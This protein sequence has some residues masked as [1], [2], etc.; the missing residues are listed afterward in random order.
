MPSVVI[1]AG[2]YKTA[3]STIQAIAQ[4]N[5]GRFLEAFGLLYPKTGARANQGIPDPDSVA[6][7]L[8]FHAAKAT[9]VEGRGRE[10]AEQFATYRTKLAA[11]V[12]KKAPRRILVS[13]ELLSFA[14]DAIKRGFLDYF[15]GIAD[16]VSVVYAVRRPD[17]MIDSM[18]NQMLRAGRGKTRSRELVDYGPD[19]EQ[20]SAR[21]GADKVKVLYFS[22]AGY[23]GYLRRMFA[24]AGVD[25]ATPGVATE[26]YANAPMT[27][28]GHVIRGMI[29]DR[30]KAR[31]VEID[32]ALRH[33]INVAL[34]PIEEKLSPS[35]KVVTLGAD[36][37]VRILNANRGELDAVKAWLSPEDRDALEAEFR[38][39]IEGPHPERNIDAPAALGK[40]DIA[41]IY[42]GLN[43]SPA[44]RRLLEAD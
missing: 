24:L 23:D 8:L 6:H 18:N 36:D 14:P 34:A 13:T 28:S 16:D 37:R 7:H 30:L 41:A 22:K 5:R 10:A 3:T 2:C 39:G 32:R 15:D 17:E 40:D 35:P 25:M 12:R 1:H 19:I 33:E 29:F 38:S 31:N 21:L 4:K 44:L 42:R 27:V 43:A 20:W 11:E 26:V 9:T